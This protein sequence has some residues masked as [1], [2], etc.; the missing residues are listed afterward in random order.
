[1]IL[2]LMISPGRSFGDHDVANTFIDEEPQTQ[3]LGIIEDDT[4]LVAEL[5]DPFSHSLSPL[6]DCHQEGVLE[7]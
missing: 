5:G 4:Y 6:L 1:M 7:L 2:S 3:V